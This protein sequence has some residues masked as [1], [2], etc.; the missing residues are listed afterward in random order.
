MKPLSGAHGRDQV[1][2]GTCFGFIVESGS[3]NGIPHGSV[4]RIA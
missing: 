3:S 2:G 1:A 4:C